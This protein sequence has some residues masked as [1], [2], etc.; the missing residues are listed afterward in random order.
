MNRLTALA[1]K[2]ATK[3]GRYADGGGLYL[4]VSTAGTKSSLYRYTLNGSNHEMGLGPVSAIGLADARIRAA[5]VR[6]LKWEGVDPLQKKREERAAAKAEDGKAITFQNAATAYSAAHKAGWKSAK[7]G[8]QWTNTLRDYAYPV[9]GD[10]P[11]QRIEVAHVMKVIEPIWRT[12]TET[13]S[14][15]RG[16]IEAVLGWAQA[17]G[18]RTGENPARWRGHLEN[19]FPV[20]Q[21]DRYRIGELPHLPP[22]SRQLP[23]SGILRTDGWLGYPDGWC[24]AM[25]ANQWVTAG[26]A[27][28]I[29][30]GYRIETDAEKLWML[31]RV[32]FAPRLTNEILRRHLDQMRRAGPPMRER[33]LAAGC[34]EVSLRALATR[35]LH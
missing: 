14:R 30:R 6:K 7:H 4:Q 34:K 18:Y 32:S 23:R 10:L 22:S 12:K 29:P 27:R 1:V 20:Q 9:F 13:A 2:R 28:W 11:V 25:Q 26:L 21:D 3:Q 5:E 17:H 35:S 24:V 16:R 8:D 19:L 31:G 33:L 15:I